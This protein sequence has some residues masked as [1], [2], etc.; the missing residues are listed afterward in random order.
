M[1]LPIASTADSL[2]GQVFET[3]QALQAAELAE[4]AATRPNNVSIGIDT[5]ASQISITATLP[6]TLQRNAYGHMEILVAPYI[7]TAQ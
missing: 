5:E 1:A 6:V 2:E 4:P 3:A 7:K